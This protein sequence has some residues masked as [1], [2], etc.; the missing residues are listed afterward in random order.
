MQPILSFQLPVHL[1]LANQ[2]AGGQSGTKPS[3]GSAQRRP[4]GFVPAIVPALSAVMLPQVEPSLWS[5][6]TRLDSQSVP[7]FRPGPPSQA[8]EFLTADPPTWHQ[9]S[10]GAS[11]PETL[12]EACEGLPP[13][14]HSLGS[15][16]QKL[17]LLLLTW[18]W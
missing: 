10:F 11:F 14:F 12:Q 7:A 6:Q 1:P 13:K 3:F 16:V 2:S 4:L 5:F 15:F 17:Q 8:R 18:P 9:E